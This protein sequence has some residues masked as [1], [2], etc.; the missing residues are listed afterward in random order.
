MFMRG[1]ECDIPENGVK[2][3]C[4]GVADDDLPDLGGHELAND[5]FPGPALV[6]LSDD[7]EESS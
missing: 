4:P 6:L 1:R 2:L 7:G 3:R 5:E